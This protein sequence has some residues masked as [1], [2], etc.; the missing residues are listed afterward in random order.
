MRIFP[1]ERLSYKIVNGFKRLCPSSVTILFRFEALLHFWNSSKK[2]TPSKYTDRPYTAQNGCLFSRWRKVTRRPFARRGF[3]FR[4]RL[5]IDPHRSR[6]A[7]G[8]SIFG[9]SRWWP[10]DSQTVMRYGP[11]FDIDRDQVVHSVWAKVHFGVIFVECRSFG[12]DIFEILLVGKSIV[13]WEC[14]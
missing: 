1:I 4:R 6:V 2:I 10:H 11:E 9:V 7:D 3:I 12:E 14:T 13:Q 8:A 5:E